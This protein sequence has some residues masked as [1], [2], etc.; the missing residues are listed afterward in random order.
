MLYWSLLAFDYVIR[1]WEWLCLCIKGRLSHTSFRRWVFTPSLCLLGT[2][3]EVWTPASAS[4]CSTGCGVCTGRHC[5]ASLH[6]T[7]YAKTV[8]HAFL[9]LPPH[10]V[11]VSA[12]R[13][14]TEKPAYSTEG[15]ITFLAVTEDTGPLMFLW[16]FG[17]RST[18]RTTYRTVTKRYRFPER[19]EKLLSTV[20]AGYNVFSFN[21][22]SL[23]FWMN[24]LHFL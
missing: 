14:Y 1:R 5:A 20:L 6:F 16:H 10:P 9:Y 3:W 15:E 21:S 17:D 24:L 7:S 8:L 12:V 13:I 4:L 2:E 18:V 22:K 19:C 11:R 23:L